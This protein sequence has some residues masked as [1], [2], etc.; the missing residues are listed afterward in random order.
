VKLYDQSDGGLTILAAVPTNLTL[1]RE[2][3]EEML[4]FFFSLGERS[5]VT[6]FLVSNS[7]L[8]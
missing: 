4:F 7:A 5:S 6:E 2:S 1:L 8:N 3:I